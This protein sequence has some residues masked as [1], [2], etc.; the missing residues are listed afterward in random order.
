MGEHSINSVR[1]FADIL[2]DEGRAVENDI[3]A[4]G[5]E[6]LFV[7]LDVTRETDWEQAVAR[8]SA[9]SGSSTSS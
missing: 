9:A 1:L 5:G 7:R 4:K 3:N 2:E 6:A 8:P